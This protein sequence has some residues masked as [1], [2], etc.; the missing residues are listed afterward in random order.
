MIHAGILLLFQTTNNKLFYDLKCQMYF[1]GPWKVPLFT[2][3]HLNMFLNIVVH[4]NL[5]E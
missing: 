2:H 4:Y 3:S 1:N 5:F